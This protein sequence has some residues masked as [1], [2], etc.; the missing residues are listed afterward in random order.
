MNKWKIA[1]WCSLVLLVFTILFSVYILFDQAVT[2][3]YRKA[4]FEW[5]E[6]DFDKIIEIIN[7]TDL[8]KNQIELLIKK[9]DYYFV[10][11]KTIMGDTIQLNTIKL[12]FEYDKL[13][14]I[15]Q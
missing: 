2:I 9:D 13:K 15:K 8:S 10:E 7:N 5:T 4:S 6:R 12:I 1:F 3:T 11:E 14:E